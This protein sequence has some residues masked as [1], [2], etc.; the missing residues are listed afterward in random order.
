VWQSQEQARA[1]P[2]RK[3][4]TNFLILFKGRTWR[5]L[6]TTHESPPEPLEMIV[7]CL[8]VHHLLGRTFAKHNRDAC[9]VALQRDGQLGCPSR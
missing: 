9:A 4:Y 5:C 3:L 2:S 1:D 8:T 6:M 7:F